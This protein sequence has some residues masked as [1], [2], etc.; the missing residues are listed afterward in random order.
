MTAEWAA[1]AEAAATAVTGNFGHR[2][3][4]IPGTWLGWVELPRA[5]PQLPWSEWHY[6]WQAQLL[7]C[8]VDAAAREHATDP[9]AAGAEPP[10]F[11]LARRLIRTIRFRNFGSFANMFFDDMAWLA[12]AARRADELSRHMRGV[13]LGA[14]RS[15]AEAL[16]R[17]LVAGDTPDLG[18]G[19]WW[20][21]SRTYKNTA[22]TGPAALFFARRATQADRRRAQALVEWLYEK[23]FDTSAGLFL[24]GIDVRR[25]ADG[26]G[27]TTTLNR[28]VWT[29][30]QG[31]V[32]GALLELGDD[33]P[34]SAQP[35]G[36][37]SAG[38]PPAG[39]QSA[40][41]PD[42]RRDLARA[43][44]L[45]TAIDRGLARDGV[46]RS[47]GTAGDPAL[48]RGILT[49]YLAL[50]ARDARLPDKTRATAG[51]L[52]LATAQN[53]WAEAAWRESRVLSAR[54][55]AW[56][57]LEAAWTVSEANRT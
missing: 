57:T 47:D 30:S 38:A 6:W 3:L 4:G 10:S 25:D 40:S 26:R 42:A 2:L 46:V 7:D 13:G 20:N 16:G 9:P 55:A 34:A 12:L 29:Y 56:M 33:E 50:A 48:F 24:D 37:P 15:A 41:T 35:A 18:G 14:A 17:R 44:E 31:P 19:M 1:R 39:A 36:A 28:D 5:R 54:L 32:L 43:A 21:T 53:A 11:T 52:V 27:A 23:L 22:A 8:L 49:R 45:V 51:R